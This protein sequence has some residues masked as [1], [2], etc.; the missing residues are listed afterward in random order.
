MKPDLKELWGCDQRWLQVGFCHRRAEWVVCVESVCVSAEVGWE[1]QGVGACVSVHVRER[2]RVCVC[3]RRN[4]GLQGKGRQGARAASRCPRCCSAPASRESSLSAPRLPLSLFIPQ[5]G[6]PR[7]PR[8]PVPESRLL[9]AAA[10]HPSLPVSSSP[11]RKASWS[12]SCELQKAAG[13]GKPL[14]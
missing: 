5:A 13:G 1:P 6:R 4:P 9:H 2:E 3:V 11:P 7:L 12:P 10:F 14:A 8:P